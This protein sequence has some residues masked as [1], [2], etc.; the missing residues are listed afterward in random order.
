MPR[1][2][3]PL[4]P[5]QHRLFL[6]QR[7]CPPHRL[8]QNRAALLKM[9]ILLVAITPLDI[10]ILTILDLNPIEFVRYTPPSLF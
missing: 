2:Q 9:S 1:S 10:S 6:N 4:I 3:Q 7:A 8:H 5:Q